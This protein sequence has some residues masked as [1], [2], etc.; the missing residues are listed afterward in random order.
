MVQN[1]VLFKGILPMQFFHLGNSEFHI[2]LC[3]VRSRTQSSAQ[4]RLVVCK[5]KRQ[6]RRQRWCL[7]VV[8]TKQPSE[9]RNAGHNVWSTVITLVAALTTTRFSTR[10]LRVRVEYPEVMTCSHIKRTCHDFRI[11][12]LFAWCAMS[13][14][15]FW[16]VR[17]VCDLHTWAVYWA[18]AFRV[19]V[20]IRRH[21]FRLPQ[22]VYTFGSTKPSMK[23]LPAAASV[24]AYSLYH[25]ALSSKWLSGHLSQW[26][27]QVIL[28]SMAGFFALTSDIGAKHDCISKCSFLQNKW[29]GA[30]DWTL[31]RFSAFEAAVPVYERL[32]WLD[33]KQLVTYTIQM[34]PRLVRAPGWL[35][36]K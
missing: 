24:G 3:F 23:L 4:P 15:F 22:G 31:T 11:L 5:R 33:F 19:S 18:L 34:P 35:L 30:R 8:C 27:T 10:R 21:A 20:T 26:V 17:Q 36:N 7:R 28:A 16:H 9:N 2:L 13:I 25:Y 32:D 12:T 14:Q 6:Q 29:N 1:L